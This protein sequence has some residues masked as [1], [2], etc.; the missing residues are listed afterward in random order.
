MRRGTWVGL[1]AVAGMGLAAWI[2][3]GPHLR[4]ETVTIVSLLPRMGGT[5]PQTDAIV[6]G[7]RLALEERDHRAGQ[8]KIRHEELDYSISA[9]GLASR[10]RR[11][12]EV[13]LEA[14][15]RPDVLAA[16]GA[17]DS[18]S[19]LSMQSAFR[20]P[21][22]SFLMI[23]PAS[24][25][26][27]LTET[28][29]RKYFRDLS[30]LP[31]APPELDQDWFFRTIPPRRAE[32]TLAARWAKRLGL[33]RVHLYQEDRDHDPEILGTFREETERE[34]I[35]VTE[36]AEAQRSEMARNQARERPD[37]IF[38]TGYDPGAAAETIG[39]LR[40]AGYRG[41]LLLGSACL[42][43]SLLKG[44]GEET[45]VYVTDSVAPPPPDFARRA[46]TAEPHAWYGYLAAKAALEAI[47]R[48]D[49]KDR[50]VVIR[51]CAGLGTFDARGEWAQPAL[52]LH[53]VV[54]GRFE[55][56]EVLR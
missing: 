1:T 8:F 41:K 4:R 42:E 17:Y 44:L 3:V 14:Y 38:M 20:P 46:G 24:T 31:S 12:E 15:G 27:D 53:R 2:L 39:L 35:A 10:G 50:S 40:R 9:G 18:A 56:V 37:L 7:I 52:G 54:R 43:P 11:A 32:G 30:R 36:S 48:A 5:K 51:A 21:E 55:L 22:P 6:A 25:R 45:E 33:K 49:S 29:A 19:T 26:S 16:I 28:E 47:A 23:S 34:G 13:F